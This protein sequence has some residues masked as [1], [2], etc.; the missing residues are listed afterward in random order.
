MKRESLKTYTF[1]DKSSW[2]EVK[3]FNKIN[4]PY[5]MFQFNYIYN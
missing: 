4:N 1:Y 2:T 5:I 3:K